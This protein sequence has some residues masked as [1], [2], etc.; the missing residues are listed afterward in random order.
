MTEIEPTELKARREK[1]EDLCILDVREA[2]EYDEI[3]IGATNIPLHDLPF[4]LQEIEHWKETELILHC[5]SGSRSVQAQKFLRS[6]G[7]TSTRNLLG[8]IQAFLAVTK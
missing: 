5:N 6:R 7:F 8:G 4:R 2:W 3:N 1:G